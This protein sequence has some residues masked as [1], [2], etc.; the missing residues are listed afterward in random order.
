MVV[1]TAEVHATS[2]DAAN[3]PILHGGSLFPRPPRATDSHCWDR[4]P[5][6]VVPIV[7]SA[8]IVRDSGRQR[9]HSGLDLQSNFAALRVTWFHP[10]AYQTRPCIAFGTAGGSPDS[11]AVSQVCSDHWTLW[12]S[13]GGPPEAGATTQRTEFHRD[14]TVRSVAGGL[15]TTLAFAEIN[16]GDF[17]MRHSVVLKCRLGWTAAALVISVLASY[18]P[19]CAQHQTDTVSPVVV[20]GPLPYYLQLRVY[21]QD[22]S[23][24]PTLHSF[25]QAQ[26]D[27]KWLLLSGRTNGLHDLTHGGMMAFPPSAQNDEVWVIDPVNRQSWH[28]SLS[29]A[30]AQLDS[31][32]VDSLS[33]TNTQFYESGDRLYITGGYG[34]RWGEGFQ[35]FDSLTAIDVAGLIDWVQTGNA[36]AADSIEQIRDPLFQVTGGAM[37]RIGELTHLV[38]GQNFAGPYTPFR[39]GIYTQQVRTFRVVDDLEGLSVTDV[40]ATAPTPEYRRRDLDVAPTLWADVEGDVPTPGLVALSGVFTENNGAWTVPVEID[41][42]G[43]PTMADPSAPETFKQGMNGYHSAKL[44]LYSEELGEMHHVLFGG[45][46]L[47]Y[48]DRRAEEMVTDNQLP[49]INQVTS[50]VRDAD[51]A[52]TQY[53]LSSEFPELI[54]QTSGKQLRFGANAEFLISP[55]IAT[56]ENEIIELDGLTQATSLGY[57]FGGIVADAPN[58][59]ETGASNIIFEVVLTPKSAGDWD[60]SGH[61]DIADLDA[62]DASIHSGEF[63]QR[64]D[65][66]LDQLV[67]AEDRRIWVVELRRT[68]F[69][70]ADLDDEFNTSDFVQVLQVGKYETNAAAGWAEG[71][72]DGD[73]KFGTSD[74]VIALQGGGYELGPRPSTRIVPEPRSWLLLIVG[75]IWLLANRRNRLS[76]DVA[77]E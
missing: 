40:R 63:D 49:F 51:G 18:G 61:L 19:L 7:T 65:L 52:Y 55:T 6:R 22:P 28:R 5:P 60:G 36:R 48:Y 27:G 31:R 42:L 74:F 14:A 41:A 38:F 70:D 77:I 1:R 53:L 17:T 56:Y 67:D 46:S 30:S 12:Y 25:A 29:D 26:H 39:E 8:K 35:T 50:I 69:G 24:L 73:G 4:D 3:F 57:I 16:V 21:D 59:G 34:F 72:W 9:Q 62:L 23:W 33:S 15:G 20:D 44:G 64:F 68:Y 2:F 54:D 11:N 75:G 32:I 37:Y 10:C 43:Q 45:I 58:R 66:N 76:G 13:L 47:Q 71:D